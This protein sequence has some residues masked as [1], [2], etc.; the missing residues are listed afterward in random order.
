MNYALCIA[1]E[2]TRYSGWQRL[3]GED[4]LQGRIENVL[5]KIFDTPIEITGSGRTDKGVHAYAQW[6][7]FKHN[8]VMEPK[9][10]LQKINTFLPADIRVLSVKHA[11]EDFHPRYS[12]VSKV[13][14]YR[15]ETGPVVSPFAVRYCHHLGYKPDL[16]KLVEAASI[17]TGTLD[18]AALS[19]AK[20]KKKSTIR[21]VKAIDFRM[22]GSML[23]VRVESNGFLYNMMRRIVTACIEVEQG[24]LTVEALKK[25]IDDK[26]RCVLA[27]QV[28]PQGLF[29]K[30][31]QF[32]TTWMNEDL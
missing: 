14:I 5:S 10:L 19:Q 26:D 12:A 4:T 30:E 22:E 29:L 27:Y 17:L 2:G 7:S 16:K 3:P 11:H 24:R 31:V 28:P 6:A 18:F 15:L 32:Q 13:Y 21:T 1:Y 20:S 8:Q 25:A 23:E 9:A